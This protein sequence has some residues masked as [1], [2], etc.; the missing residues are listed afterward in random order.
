MNKKQIER[1]SRKDRHIAGLMYEAIQDTFDLCEKLVRIHAKKK[2]DATLNAIADEFRSS[3]I[4][5]EHIYDA[6]SRAKAVRKK[7]IKGVIDKTDS[8]M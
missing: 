3:A 5:I 2:K 4:N 8:V 1:K 6:I 7:P